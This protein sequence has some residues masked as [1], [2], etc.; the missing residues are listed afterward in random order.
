MIKTAHSCSRKLPFIFVRFKWQLNFLDIFSK[1]SQISN[2]MNIRL[3]GTELFYGTDGQMD[4]HDET[5]SRFLQI[6]ER[7]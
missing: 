1:H 2:F 5:N 7:A 6:Y 4:R 3:V